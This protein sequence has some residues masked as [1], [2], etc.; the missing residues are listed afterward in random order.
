MAPGSW[1]RCVWL[2]LRLTI[3]VGV[4]A[5]VYQLTMDN[6]M[7]VIDGPHH[8]IVKFYA[9][10][11]SV[12]QQIAPYFLTTSGSYPTEESNMIFAEVDAV[13]EQFIA[14]ELGITHY[15][16]YL[17]FPD[18]DPDSF[19]E[20]NMGSNLHQMHAFMNNRF[21]FR[22]RLPVP[23]VPHLISQLESEEDFFRAVETRTGA[24]IVNMY[25]ESCPYN[26]LNMHMNLPKIA[27]IFQNED[28]KFARLHGEDQSRL[29]NRFHAIFYPSLIFFPKLGD[30]VELFD[31]AT[32]D[33][34]H[35][36]YIDKDTDP[37]ALLKFI[38]NE[39]GTFRGED[40]SLLPEA[41]NIPEL[42]AIIY[43][44]PNSLEDP[45][46]QA[47]LN[48]AASQLP[49]HDSPYPNMTPSYIR[50][51]Q[52]IQEKG[53]S[54]IKTEMRRYENALL[55]EE[56]SLQ[57]KDDLWL[58]FNVLTVFNEKMNAIQIGELQVDRETRGEE[59]GE[60]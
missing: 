21:G 31:N 60:L 24:L 41:G 38:N 29:V 9:P 12:C 35:L 42:D 23:D 27:R 16:T 18:G 30:G 7:D 58:A 53:E 54:F 10:W 36:T 17:Y 33:Y 2:W 13:E 22:K 19:E 4:Q 25:G 46:L 52:N 26:C 32:K 49:L 3:L 56:L 14:D 8:K 15:P 34:T 57:D 37:V 47:A 55:D 59:L 50:T 43:A 44:H 45:S 40:G 51:A 11:C 5:D 1:R 48:A 39:M 6:F 20:I 28:I